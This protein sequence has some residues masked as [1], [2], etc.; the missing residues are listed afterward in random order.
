MSFHICERRIAPSQEMYVVLQNVAS[1]KQQRG[2]HDVD[3]TNRPLLVSAYV[4]S[5]IGLSER[6]VIIDTCICPGLSLY[7]LMINHDTT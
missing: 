5:L 1:Q 3:V 2:Q 7:M 4:T 6:I